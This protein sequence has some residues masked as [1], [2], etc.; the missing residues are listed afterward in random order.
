MYVE[1]VEDIQ[2]ATLIDELLINT[3]ELIDSGTK[4]TGLDGTD[5]LFILDDNSNSTGA[6][7]NFSLSG[8]ASGAASLSSEVNPSF[9]LVLKFVPIIS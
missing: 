7:N 2:S 5:L 4:S 8:E 3:I 6:V 9:N 1:D